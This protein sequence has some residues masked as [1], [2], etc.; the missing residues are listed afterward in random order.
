MLAA[1]TAEGSRMEFQG[2]DRLGPMDGSFAVG[3][4][5]G[6]WLESA[7]RRDEREGGRWGR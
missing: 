3:G 1:G 6:R 7:Y 2:G 4:V 5:T